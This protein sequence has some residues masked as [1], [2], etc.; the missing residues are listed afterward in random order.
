MFF[1]TP[2]N[3]KNLSFVQNDA[4]YIYSCVIL[5]VKHRKLAILVSEG[6]ILLCSRGSLGRRGRVK[7]PGAL[8]LLPL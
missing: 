3:N 1:S 5:R 2:L 8:L 4:K 7:L 6:Y